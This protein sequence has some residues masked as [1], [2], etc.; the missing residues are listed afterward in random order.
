[1]IGN[2]IEMIEIKS[3]IAV[4]KVELIKVDAYSFI[5]FFRSRTPFKS[6]SKVFILSLHSNSL[7]TDASIFS[8]SEN[9][10]LSSCL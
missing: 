7:L 4:L 1:M 2:E 10:F 5:A 8:T 9:S 6:P 3:K